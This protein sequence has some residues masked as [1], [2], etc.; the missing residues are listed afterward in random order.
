MIRIASRQPSVPVASCPAP[1]W[2]AGFLAMLPIVQEYARR[3]FRHLKGD[4]RED[5]VEEVIANVLVAY[6]RLVELKNTGVAHPTVLTRYAIVQVCDGRR[7]GN[8]LNVHEVLSQ[9]AQRTKDFTVQRLDRFDKEDG[10][11]MEAV[12]EDHRTPVADQAAFRI[13][14]PAWLAIH[15]RRDRR[16]A[17]TLAA[18]HSTNE[19]ARRFHVSPGRVSQ[20]RR[21]LQVSWQRFHGEQPL[22]SGVT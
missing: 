5:A 16:I 21:E 2:H 11:W 22:E 13:D 1:A 6:V 20:K 18:G 12:V 17:E 14:F 9:Y 15:P 7:V 3:A 8:H 19:T 4:E 10:E